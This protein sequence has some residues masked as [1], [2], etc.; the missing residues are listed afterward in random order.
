MDANSR[1]SPLLGYGDEGR[2]HP[3]VSCAEGLVV[4]D[5]DYAGEEKVAINPKF[6]PLRADVLTFYSKSK[7]ARDTVLAQAYT[8]KILFFDMDTPLLYSLFYSKLKVKPQTDTIT[9]CQGFERML[10]IAHS[11]LKAGES[12]EQITKALTELTVE[13][14]MLTEDLIAKIKDPVFKESRD[15]EMENALADLFI[16]FTVSYIAILERCCWRLYGHF[17]DAEHSFRPSTV[18][19]V[20]LAS[21]PSIEGQGKHCAELWKIQTR[22]WQTRFGDAIPLENQFDLTEES[23]KTSRHY[24]GVDIVQAMFLFDLYLQES[25]VELVEKK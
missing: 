7:E 19:P 14:D 10:F 4:V 13:M 17:T 2:K 8:A 20:D 15:E 25:S 22:C 1:W 11:K 21:L 9:I 12:K 6:M 18:R 3:M 23:F 5:Y 16:P 24:Y